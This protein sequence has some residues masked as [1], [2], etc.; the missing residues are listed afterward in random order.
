MAHH[1]M[2]GMPHCTRPDKHSDSTNLEA[3]AV[4][5]PGARAATCLGEVARTRFLRIGGAHRV[6][7]SP[8][9]VVAHVLNDAAARRRITVRD[10]VERP[11][12]NAVLLQQR[13]SGLGDVR[14]VC[15]VRGGW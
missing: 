2:S 11:A 5:L 1:G 3:A 8:A 6:I 13:L 12:Q 15:A 4:A 14:C 9:R 7:G 10:A